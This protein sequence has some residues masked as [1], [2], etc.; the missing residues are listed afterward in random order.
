MST[1]TTNP[2]PTT[3]PPISTLILRAAR[4]L[5]DAG[6]SQFSAEVL[7][8]AA[9][10]MAPQTFGLSGFAEQYP[11]SN[12]VIAAL[13]GKRGLVRQGFLEKIAP[14]LYRLAPAGRERLAPPVANGIAQPPRF[15]RAAAGALVLKLEATIAAEKHRA[16]RKDELT[17][18]E[19]CAFWGITEDDRGE[20]IGQRVARITD[21]LEKALRATEAGGLVLESGRLLTAEDVERVLRVSD[22]M[23]ARFARHVALLRNRK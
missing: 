21:G 1:A 6:D 13:S 19:A 18:Q 15:T 20:R 16:G 22:Y 14:K 10:R 11:C 8:L 5:E 12:K 3:R 2:A 4:Q 9:W 17:F 7:I 23:A